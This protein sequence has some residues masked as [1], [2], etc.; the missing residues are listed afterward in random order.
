MNCHENSHKGTKAQRNT[1]G[2]IIK[3]SL[4]PWR[5][6]GKHFDMKMTGYDS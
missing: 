1:K 5:F 6:G 3:K 4:A 2:F